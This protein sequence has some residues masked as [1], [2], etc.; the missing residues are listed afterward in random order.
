MTE[1]LQD[2]PNV[3]KARRVMERPEWLDK[4]EVYCENCN[5][6]AINGHGC[7]EFG[8]PT[9]HFDLVTGKPA[10]RECNWC[11]MQFLPDAKERFCSETCAE[12]Y[13]L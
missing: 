2:L 10:S 5:A 4:N 3:D 1:C 7:H 11:G 13:S 8:C 12:D 9:E 6:V